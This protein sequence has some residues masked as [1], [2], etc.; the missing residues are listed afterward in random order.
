MLLH[1]GQS[2]VHAAIIGAPAR[3]VNGRTGRS[4]VGLSHD[5][6]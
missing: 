4:F 1:H 3:D 6:P 2:I 5:C